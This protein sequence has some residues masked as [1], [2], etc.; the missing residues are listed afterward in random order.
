MNLSIVIP[1]FN[2][3]SIIQVSLNSLINQDL[4][5]VEIII[6]DDGSNDNTYNIALSLLKSNNV[7]NYKVIKKLNEGVSIARNIGIE[8]ASGEYIYFLDSDDYVSNNFIEEFNKVISKKKPDAIFWGFNTENENKKIINY[9]FNKYQYKPVEVLGRELLY[10]ILVNKI[11]SI[12]TG[13][14]VYKK[15]VI[16][17]NNLRYFPNCINGEDQEFIYKA[18]INIDKAVFINKILSNYV[19]RDGSVSNSFNIKKFDVVFALKRTIEYLFTK[20]NYKLDKE[21]KQLENAIVTNYF[22]T[23]Q[24]NINYLNENNLN[25]LYFEIEKAYPGLNNYVYNLIK[26]FKFINLRWSI[27][28]NLF[29]VSPIILGYYLYIISFLGKTRTYIEKIK[30]KL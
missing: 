11:V 27:K 4:S 14:I 21:I 28:L 29:K 23:L 8:K 18:L 25:Q 9:Y 16:D 13:S 30:F 5:N 26:N 10:E 3:E 20:S 7:K 24:A 19:Y 6:I 15:S 1:A 17:K 12:C 2:V 22:I